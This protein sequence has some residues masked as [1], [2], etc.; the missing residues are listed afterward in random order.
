VGFLII[1]EANDG[2]IYKIPNVS[3]L[4]ILAPA[5]VLDISP[6]DCLNELN[7][8]VP[9]IGKWAIGTSRYEPEKKR[10]LPYRT[11]SQAEKPIKR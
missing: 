5:N 2:R 7:Y 10:S 4:V 1:A 11:G 3:S 8:S 6:L 9:G